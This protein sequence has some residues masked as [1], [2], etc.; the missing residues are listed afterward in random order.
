MSKA[1]GFNEF[2]NIKIMFSDQAI[3]DTEADLF[4]RKH[5]SERIAQIIATRTEK[6]SIVIGIHAPWGE[7]KTS[8]L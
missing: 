7:G 1:V 2:V 5:F 6:E 3:K 4:D 8:V